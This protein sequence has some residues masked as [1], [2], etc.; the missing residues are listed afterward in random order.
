MSLAKGI[1]CESY[2]RIMRV[3][4]EPTWVARGVSTLLRSPPSLK[5]FDEINT[6]LQKVQ[7][8]QTK[9]TPNILAHVRSQVNSDGDLIPMSSDRI[10]YR[11]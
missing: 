4:K 8:F 1:L 11:K 9:K 6:L 10:F 7:I 5:A 3:K 2:E